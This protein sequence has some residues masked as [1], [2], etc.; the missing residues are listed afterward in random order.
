MTTQSRL[1]PLALGGVAEHFNTP[2][3]RAIARGVF[4]RHGLAVSFLEC[5]GGTGQQLKQLRSGAI[6][7]CV[8]LTEGL[9]TGLLVPPSSKGTTGYR[10]LGTLV[11][12][13]LNWMVAT[14]ASST[15][16]PEQVGDPSVPVRLAISRPFSGSHLIPL[17]HRGSSQN[18]TFV[19]R[20]DFAAMRAA[21]H[22]GDADGFLWDVSTTMPYVSGPT[23]EP[24]L[25]AA[26]TVVPAWPAFAVAVRD[27]VSPVAAAALAAGIADALR[28]WRALG[29]DDRVAAVLELLPAYTPDGVA[30]WAAH[31]AYSDPDTQEGAV[32]WPTVSA[33][34]VASVVRV[35]VDAGVLDRVP[36]LEV[37]TVCDAAT[38]VVE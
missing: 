25:R 4:A 2:L 3:R 10:L 22:S 36:D 38:R 32:A 23:D 6:D 28:E 21:V 31:T 7:A 16:T 27:A 34:M 1:V 19:E 17:T 14:S 29:A 24:S 35:L 26:G 5:P 13:P 8:A 18:L 20:G 15:L 12:T 33:R 9:V 11:Q 30:M 37:A